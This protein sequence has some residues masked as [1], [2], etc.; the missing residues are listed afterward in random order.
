MEAEEEQRRVGIIVE[1]MKANEILKASVVPKKKK[2]RKFRFSP[3]G[4]MREHDKKKAKTKEYRGKNAELLT[5]PNVEVD[6]TKAE[7]KRQKFNKWK[8]MR[9]RGRGSKARAP[10]NNQN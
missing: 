5:A 7:K 1:S 2:H 4:R 9:K 8:K 3:A 10:M 6:L